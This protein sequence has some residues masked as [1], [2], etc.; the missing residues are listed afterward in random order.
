M[1]RR[2]WRALFIK[3][4]LPLLYNPAPLWH[5]C[6]HVMSIAAGYNDATLPFVRRGMVLGGLGEIRAV[7]LGASES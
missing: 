4:V 7:V 5:D 6:G 2:H 3:Q 1:C